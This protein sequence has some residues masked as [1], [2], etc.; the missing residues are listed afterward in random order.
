MSFHGFLG[1]LDTDLVKFIPLL[2]KR[3][4][5]HF[6]DGQRLGG[7]DDQRDDRCE[8]KPDT[9]NTYYYHA[10]RSPDYGPSIKSKT[11]ALVSWFSL[12]QYAGFL[13]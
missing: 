11:G 9:Y 12:K 5:D 10:D 1:G 6:V 7:V 2:T 8:Q 13:R 4:D 3:R